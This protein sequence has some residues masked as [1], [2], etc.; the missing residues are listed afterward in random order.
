MSNTDT[1]NGGGWTRERLERLLGA[2]RADLAGQIW[3]ALADLGEDE[4]ARC[5]SIIL[6]PLRRCELYAGHPGRVHWSGILSAAVELRTWTDLD[7]DE[8]DEWAPA[9]LRALADRRSDPGENT[10]G[11]AHRDAGDTEQAAAERVRPR[12]GT[13]RRRVLA[14]FVRAY[15]EGRTDDELVAELGLT[16]NSVRPRRVELVRGGWLVDSGERRPTPTG[17][18]AVVWE[19]TAGAVS[20]LVAE[21]RAAVFALA[22]IEDR[23]DALDPDLG[24][25]S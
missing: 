1:D 23:L 3:A 13:Q 4:P 16:P 17:S 12:T 19:L 18:P 24:G 8:L 6:D 14:A 2:G 7:T 21:G 22:G 9:H 20:D 5:A 11:Q 15:P 10:V 25:D